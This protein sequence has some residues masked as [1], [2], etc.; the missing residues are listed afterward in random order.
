[1]RRR[2][3]LQL[4][5]AAGTTAVPLPGW[6]ADS[7]S[8][9]LR[10]SA[11][12]NPST[13]DPAKGVS[14]A[15]HVFL[16]TIYDTLT[17]WD[18]ATL[19]AKPGLAESW[20]FT[21]PQTLVL[22]LRQGV[23]FHD[24][25]PFDA[26]A[27]KFNIERGKSD[28]KSSI[29]GD[30]ASVDSVEAA[31]P[32]KVVLKLNRPNSALV[33]ILSDRAGMMVSPAA[34]QAHAAEFDRN[35]VGSGAWRYVSWTDNGKV[36]VRRNETYWRK[37]APKV[38]GLELAIIPDLNTGLRSVVAGEND[39]VYAITPRLK[40]VADRGG[41]LETDTQPTVG[42]S[43]IYF[44]LSLAPITDVRVRQA[45]NF[46][47]DRDVFNKAVAS[48]LGEVAKMAVPSHHWAYDPSLAGVYPHDPDKARKLLADAG[49]GGGIDIPMLG[50]SDQASQQAQEVLIDMLGKVGIRPKMKV[51]SIADTSTQFYGPQNKD[52]PIYLSGWSGRPDPTLTYT[53]MFAKNGFYNAGRVEGAPGTDDAILATQASTDIAERKRA[54]S[55][56]QHL[57]VDNALFCPLLFNPEIDAFSHKVKNFKPNLLGKPKFTDV[58]VAA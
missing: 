45:I 47:I 15:D 26:A 57:V 21:D 36:V 43:L 51:G 25:T 39:L 52:F 6:S 19:E 18:F 30:L 53:L 41:S 9:V 32:N 1:M 28:A 5:A 14:G 10:I 33:L 48:G 20:E 13:L 24:G 40:A 12:T 31:A 4:L 42:F 8:A 38:D 7:A 17:E 27:V 3:F 44:N 29:K 50:W 49:F 46:A 16:Y 23:V 34:V 54:F 2:R 56:L 37:D 11:P 35:P 55:A 22:N 58:S